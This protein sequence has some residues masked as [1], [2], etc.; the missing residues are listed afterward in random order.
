[1]TGAG[2]R[3]GTGREVEGLVN[4]R[5]SAIVLVHGIHAITGTMGVGHEVPYA[6]LAVGPG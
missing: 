1:M 3:T 2:V 5:F 6:V 4:R